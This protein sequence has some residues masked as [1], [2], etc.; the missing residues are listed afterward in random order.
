MP[1][2]KPQI[3]ETV[4]TLILVFWFNFDELNDDDS[5]LVKLDLKPTL[6]RVNFKLGTLVGEGGGRFERKKT[7]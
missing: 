6:I 7:S 5:Q 4:G 1:M 2:S 3:G